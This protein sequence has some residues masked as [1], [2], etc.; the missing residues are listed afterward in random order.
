[1]RGID[2]LMLLAVALLLS[3]TDAGAASA[4]RDPFI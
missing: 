4:A 2:A 1:M 3:R